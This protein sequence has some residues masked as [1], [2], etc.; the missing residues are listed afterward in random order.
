MSINQSGY[1]PASGEVELGSP[2]REMKAGMRA[3]VFDMAASD[4]N[5]SVGQG[6]AAGAVDEGGTHQC[7]T[8]RRALGTGE[9]SQRPEHDKSAGPAT[10]DHWMNDRE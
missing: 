10:A 7:H 9:A 3:D 1:D 6:R 2:A 5:R 8:V 4:H